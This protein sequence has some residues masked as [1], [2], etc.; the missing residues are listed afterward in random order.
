MITFKQFI[1]EALIDCPNGIFVKVLPTIQSIVEIKR[2]FQQLESRQ[3]MLDDLHATL[4]YSKTSINNIILPHVDKNA[5][6]NAE[7]TSL[8]F[9]PGHDNEGYVVMKLSSPDL[10]TLNS[11]FRDAGLVGTFP[12]YSPHVSLLHPVQNA[13]YYKNIIEQLNAQLAS[14]PINLQFYYG[15]Y[16]LLE[17]EVT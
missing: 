15:G 16:V 3:S 5:R 14:N 1:K 4:M 8:E 9:W 12:N 17:P 2:R 6:F 11:K 13:E 7:G 10:V